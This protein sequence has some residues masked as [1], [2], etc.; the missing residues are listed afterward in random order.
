MKDNHEWRE[1]VGHTLVEKAHRKIQRECLKAYADEADEMAVEE[2]A[3]IVMFGTGELNK[4]S[5]A[6]IKEQLADVCRVLS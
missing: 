2:Q 3:E 6:S 5:A 1:D 4:A